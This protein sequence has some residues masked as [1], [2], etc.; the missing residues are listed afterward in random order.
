LFF[1][2]SLKQIWNPKNPSYIY[3]VKL[4]IKTKFKTKVMQTAVQTIET[5]ETKQR[6]RKSNP[7]SAR[8]T[9]LA[10]KSALENA[11]VTIQRGRKPNPTSDRQQRLAMFAERIANGDV[12]KRG[13]PKN[14]AAENAA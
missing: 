4:I 1:F 8:Q 11:G 13:R 9:K 10:L 14:T 12:V 7:N 6:G 2:F 5:V 3:R